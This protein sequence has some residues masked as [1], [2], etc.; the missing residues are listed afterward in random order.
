MIEAPSAELRCRRGPLDDDEVPE[1]Y[2]ECLGLQRVRVDGQEV[3]PEDALLFVTN[4]VGVQHLLAALRARHHDEGPHHHADAA[5]A[6][7]HAVRAALTHPARQPECRIV[8]RALPT[9]TPLPLERRREPFDHRD[10][11]FELKLDGFR[12]LAYVEHGQV[13]LVSRNGNTFKRFAPL[14]AE[15]AVTLSADSA[16]ERVNLDSVA[17]AS[18]AMRTNSAGH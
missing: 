8:P 16:R 4:P 11:L 10:F 2:A 1:Q 9:F 13:R 12:A 17:R 3:I 15:I 18:R 5:F 6:T 7:E 14:A